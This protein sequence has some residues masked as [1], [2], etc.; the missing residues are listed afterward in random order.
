LAG[1]SIGCLGFGVTKAI[2]QNVCSVPV[3]VSGSISLGGC[4]SATFN[5]STDS[6]NIT[7]YSFV[8]VS[9]GVTAAAPVIAISTNSLAQLQYWNSP[10]APWVGGTIPIVD[11][12]NA[13]NI[14]AGIVSAPYIAALNVPSDVNILTNLGPTEQTLGIPGLSWSSSIFG[15]PVSVGAS[16]DLRF[17]VTISSGANID[18]NQS[19]VVVQSL[20]VRSGAQLSDVQD[21]TVRDDLSNSGFLRMGGAQTPGK[22]TVNGTLYN[23]GTLWFSTTTQTPNSL[24]SGSPVTLVNQAGGVF[25]SGISPLSINLSQ[26]SRNQGVIQASSGGTLIVNSAA[27]DNTAGTIQ[28]LNGS[29]VYLYSQITGG[30]IKALSNSNVQVN[31]TFSDGTVTAN[32]GGTVSFST[33]TLS[34]VTL[35]GD[36]TGAFQGVGGFFPALNES[37]SHT[38]FENVTLESGVTYTSLARNATILRGTINNSGILAVATGG[39]FSVD[40]QV[41]LTG[42]GQVK[43]DGGTILSVPSLKQSADPDRLINVNNTISGAGSINIDV[44]NKATIDAN[45]AGPV[46]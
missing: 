11:G 32:T 13:S 30:D 15:V 1:T 17:A 44:T 37:G 38:A 26:Q 22:L 29:N 21:L 20:T 27:F 39:Y 24:N 43:L 25:D 36:G 33:V 16:V 3:T 8:E 7:S 45:Y 19:P 10:G 14:V 5:S 23:S 42:S 35:K 28:A 18:M 6:N 31:G 46:K 40:G 41:T 12:I 34:N 9:G 2:A 4:V